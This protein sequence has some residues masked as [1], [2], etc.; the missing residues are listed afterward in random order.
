MG[1]FGVLSRI[2]C[3]NVL[4]LV[5]VGLC[6][7]C[8]GV[9]LRRLW[10]GELVFR[11]SEWPSGTFHMYWKGREAVSQGWSGGLEYHIPCPG[12][13][14]ISFIAFFLLIPK[15]YLCFNMESTMHVS[16]KRKWQILFASQPMEFQELRDICLAA[17]EDQRRWLQGLG[18]LL[19]EGL[20]PGRH[21]LCWGTWK[22]LF[23]MYLVKWAW[24]V[25]GK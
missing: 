24:L 17:Q 7:Q 2:S 13:D 25:K 10:D 6:Q 8:L 21:R 3:L 4:L 16:Q 14:C 20:P 15:H 12:K 18:Q 1:N 23:Q 19:R 11:Q 9:H 5:R 22:K